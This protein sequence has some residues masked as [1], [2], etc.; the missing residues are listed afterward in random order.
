[1]NQLLENHKNFTKEYES[2]M[3]ALENDDLLT[4]N[5]SLNKELLET[6]DKL[7]SIEEKYKAKVESNL[8]LKIALRD[9][10]LNEKTAILNASKQK[11]ELYFKNETQK[12]ENKLKALESSTKNRINKIQKVVNNQLDDEKTEMLEKLNEISLEVESLIKEKQ[13]KIGDEKKSI[14]EE[15]KEEYETLKK[16]NLPEEVI[17]KKKKQ[18]NLEVKIGLNWV[19]KIGIII[20]LL[21]IATTMQYTYSTWFNAYMKGISGFLVGGVFLVGGEWFNKKRKTTFSL[22]LC[23]AG[24]A[25]LYITI[26]SSYF[27]LDILSIMVAILFSVLVTGVAI[28]LSQRYNSMSIC[29]ISL[30]GGYL[31]F[32]SYSYMENLI[33][34]QVY[35]AMGYLLVLNLLVLI[36]SIDKRWIKLNYLSFI[37]NMPSLLYLL[38]IVENKNFGL[39]YSLVTF[40]MYL[41]ITLIYPLIRKI[42]LR[43]SDIILLAINTVLNSLITYSLFDQLNYN[44]YFG[45]LALLYSVM[46]LGLANII[47]KN[48]NEEKK[49]IGLFYITAMTFAVLM[50]PFQFGVE[51]ALFGWLIE[52]VLILTFAVKHKEVQFEFAGWIILGLSFVSFTFFDFTYTFQNFY[53]FKYFSLTASLIYV[54]WLYLVSFPDETVL[55]NTRKYKLL[56]FYRYFVI[57]NT[58]VYALLTALYFFNKYIHLTYGKM[59]FRILLFSIITIMFGYIISNIKILKD[60][61]VKIIAIAFYIVGDLAFLSLNYNAFYV[62]D[63]RGLKFLIIGILI[64][65]N[66]FVFFN[67]KALALKLLHYTKVSFEFYPLAL[68]IYLLG[69]MSTFLINQFN[70]Q[71]INLIISILFVVLSFIYIYYGFKTNYMLLR[72][73][74]LGLSIFSTAKLFL[75]DLSFLDTIGKIVAYFCFGLILISISFIYQKLKTE[76]EES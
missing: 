60:K 43:L 29:G 72:R 14:L 61:I 49:T 26:F 41:G 3:N 22:G 52:A 62:N 35:I 4:K 59:F 67:I 69:V 42:K 46:Y 2:L 18:N 58:W 57:I 40:L 17:E 23:S 73:F 6:K 71:N 1:M 39:I 25:I 9:Q 65:Y 45:F 34:S 5:F 7:N 50:I 48:I 36:I 11:I 31:P 74:G 54:L 33:G 32:F 28:V 19:N 76:I 30:I 15:L 13:A 75:F 16:E 21:G 8:G 64:F 55:T 66:I 68:A 20:L 47:T 38:I 53:Q 10:I 27:M 44:D 70:F 24:I 56:K 37:L 63:N 12:N 51:W